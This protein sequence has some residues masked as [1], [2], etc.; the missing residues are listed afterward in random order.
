MNIPEIQDAVDQFKLPRR[1]VYEFCKRLFDICFA[2]FGLILAGPVMIVIAITIKVVSPGPVL[3]KGLRTGRHGKP[4]YIKKFRSMVIDAD[5][6][7]STTSKNDPRVTPIGRFI[8]ANKLDEL[9][10]LINVLKGEM[11]FVG[12][13]PELPKY[14]NQYNDKEQLI[15]TVPPGITDYSSLHFSNLNE[16]IGDDD[17]DMAFETNILTEKNQLRVKYVENR[18]FFSDIMLIINTILRVLRVK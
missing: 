4:F 18:N 1:P 14:T 15:L 2:L 5:K 16:L 17:P 3:Y 9:P 8:R 11:S 6:S 10:Q 12:P 13:R 7:A